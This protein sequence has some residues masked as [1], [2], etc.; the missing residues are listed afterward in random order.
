LENTDPA[1]ISTIVMEMCKSSNLTANF[2]ETLEYMK[3][4]LEI[5]SKYMPE[6]S[7]DHCKIKRTI[8][9]LYLK[10]KKHK[11]ALEVL[12]SIEVRN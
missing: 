12:K 2:E 7:K 1:T 5:F 9:L 8:S 6:V 3:R 4:G 11:E 10:A